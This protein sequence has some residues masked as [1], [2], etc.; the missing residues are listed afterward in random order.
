M[1][2]TKARLTQLASGD[3]GAGGDESVRRRFE[4]RHASMMI[5]PFAYNAFLFLD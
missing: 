5:H 3:L 1:R 4:R 2:L